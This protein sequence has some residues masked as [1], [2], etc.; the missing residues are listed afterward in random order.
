MGETGSAVGVP[1]QFPNQI[2]CFLRFCRRRLVALV[3]VAEQGEVPAPIPSYVLQQ[4]FPGAAKPRPASPDGGVGAAE[5][6]N[7]L[8][9]EVLLLF[10]ERQILEFHRLYPPLGGFRPVCGASAPPCA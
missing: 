5:L 1:I 3:V 8:G 2:P 9:C 6:D 10:I 7:L 4:R